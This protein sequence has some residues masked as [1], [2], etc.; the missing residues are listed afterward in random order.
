MKKY[1]ARMHTLKIFIKKNIFLKI[2]FMKNVNIL[3]LGRQI[4]SS[5]SVVFTLK[6]QQF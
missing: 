3:V 6:Q 4:C 5:G 2:K 1:H